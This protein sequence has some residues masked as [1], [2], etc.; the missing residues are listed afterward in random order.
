MYSIAKDNIVGAI[1]TDTRSGGLVMSNFTNHI[2]K[3]DRNICELD[4][5]QEVI[6]SIDSILSKLNFSSFYAGVDQFTNKSYTDDKLISNYINGCH[7]FMYKPY[8]AVLYHENNQLLFDCLD[9]EFMIRRKCIPNNWINV[10]SSKLYKIQRR[11]GT[12]QKSIILDNQSLRFSRSQPSVL[13][14]EQHFNVDHSDPDLSEY[15]YT[16]CDSHK[17]V[18]IYNFGEINNIASVNIKIPFINLDNYDELLITD[19]LANTVAKYY[20]D[21]I[22]GYLSYIKNVMEDTNITINENEL[23]INFEK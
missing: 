4:T 13:V 21:K 6:N 3:L 1:K 11:D 7:S 19:Y 17:T 23:V 18:D 5:L 8:G 22:T 20:N 12:I 9:I 14:I 16:T 10:D 2:L 15:G